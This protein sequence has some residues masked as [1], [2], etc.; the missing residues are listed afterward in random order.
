[1]C[2]S[3]CLKRASD[4]IYT[5]PHRVIGWYDGRDN[6]RR[7][8]TKTCIDCHTREKTSN[9]E[10]PERYK[11]FRVLVS[12]IDLRYESSVYQNT[13]RKNIREAKHFYDIRPQNTCVRKINIQIDRHFSLSTIDLRSESYFTGHKRREYRL[14][15][16]WSV[17]DFVLVS[18]HYKKFL[19]KITLISALNVPDPKLYETTFDPFWNI[20]Q[21]QV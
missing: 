18:F 7:I 2:E 15:C 9:T 20:G 11:W 5:A 16:A 10:Y 19:G 12:P 8:C 3:C 1:M 6:R 13:G 17:I 14:E 21:G 4:N